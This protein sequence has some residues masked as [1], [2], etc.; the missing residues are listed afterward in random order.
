MRGKFL[1][2]L[3]GGPED[4]ARTLSFPVAEPVDLVIGRQAGVAISLRSSTVSRQHA[5]IEVRRE[6][7][8]LSDLGSSNGT[9]VNGRPLQG[10]RALEVGDRISIAEYTLEVV[11]TACDE[12]TVERPSIPLDPIEERLLADIVATDAASRLVYADWLEGRGQLARAEFLRLQEELVSTPE[13]PGWELRSERLREL[14]LGIDV[15]WRRK[16]ARPA[17]EGCPTKFSLK[18]PKEWGALEPT[19]RSNIRRCNACA[20]DVYYCL[21]VGQARE[22][23]ARGQCVAVDLRATRWEHDLYGPFGSYLCHACKADLGPGSPRRCP[24]CDAVQERLVMGM[25]A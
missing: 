22:H 4:A 8:I 10:T 20:R 18:C 2:L 1:K 23:A 5:R 9:L 17:V 24:M 11:D 21:D 16:V 12:I 13:V 3:V 6:R 7:C 25:I 14:A 15:Q 19:G